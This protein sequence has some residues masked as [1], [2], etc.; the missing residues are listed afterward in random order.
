MF[1]V[2]VGFGSWSIDA[3]ARQDT[4]LLPDQRLSRVIIMMILL[5]FIGRIIAG[6][7]EA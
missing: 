2:T 4:A 3:L 7:Q 1:V 5:I 6:V